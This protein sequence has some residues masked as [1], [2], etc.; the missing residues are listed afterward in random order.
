L[1][2]YNILFWLAAVTERMAIYMKHFSPV[3]CTLACLIA[4]I[5]DLRLLGAYH[6]AIMH[7]QAKQ[8]QKQKEKHGKAKQKKAG[9]PRVGWI[10][11]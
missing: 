2:Y 8:D 7:C 9:N 4:A 1:L 3:S 6:G 10:S 5:V 11:G